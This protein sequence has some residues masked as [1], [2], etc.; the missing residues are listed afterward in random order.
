V[1]AN[2]PTLKRS[3]VNYLLE[4]LIE[5]NRMGLSGKEDDD[6]T[7]SMVMGWWS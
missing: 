7:E 6:G 5:M 4:L 3:R 2:A 1:A